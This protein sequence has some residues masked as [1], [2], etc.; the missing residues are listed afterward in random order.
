MFLFRYLPRFHLLDHRMWLY[1]PELMYMPF[2]MLKKKYFSEEVGGGDLGVVIGI[3]QS[4]M[5]TDGFIIVILHPGTEE[6][7]MIGDIIIATISG[8]VVLGILIT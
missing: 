4:T 5:I 2:P 1:C 8:M 3:V 7:L 6:Y